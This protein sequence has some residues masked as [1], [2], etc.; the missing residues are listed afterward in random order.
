MDDALSLAATGVTMRWTLVQE[1]HA[2]LAITAEGAGVELHVT[3]VRDSFADLLAAASDIKLGAYSTYAVLSG[4]PAGHV[5]FFSSLAEAEAVML[6]VVAFPAIS[7]SLTRFS[8]GELR[9]RGF[10][11][12]Q[13]LVDAA[14]D[15]AAEVLAEHGET[16]YER[17]WGHPFPAGLAARLR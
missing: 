4:E 13:A 7:A 6:D 17:R 1:R 14:A 16:G 10:L 5:L 3:Y 12:R 11:S 9:W 15:M 2:A 8:A